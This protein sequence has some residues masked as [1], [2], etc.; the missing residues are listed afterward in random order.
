MAKWF[1]KTEHLATMRNVAL[2]RAE[3]AMDKGATLQEVLSHLDS[4]K[5]T[6]ERRQQRDAHA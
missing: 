6:L 3:K 1:G 5:R 2:L 4:V